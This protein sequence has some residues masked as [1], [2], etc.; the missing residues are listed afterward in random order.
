MVASQYLNASHSSSSF[1][2]IVRY[3]IL[4]NERRAERRHPTKEAR[5]VSV[6]ASAQP[7]TYPPRLWLTLG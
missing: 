3:L 5:S 6:G 4:I 2:Q 7:A 1:A